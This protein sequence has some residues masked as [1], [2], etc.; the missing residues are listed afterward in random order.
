MRVGV[1]R[2]DMGRG[3]HLDDLLPRNQYPYASQVAGQSR[4]IHKPTDAELEAA[5][6]PY[7][8]LAT[9]VLIATNTAA[10]V[11]TSSND[12][13]RIRTDATASFTVIAVTSGASTA[14]TVIRDDLNTEF[15]S[16][17]LNLI[18][19]IVGTNQIRIRTTSPDV[20]PGSYV[21]VDSVANGSTLSTAVGFTVGG[22][23]DTVGTSTA[24]TAAIKAAV[25]PTSTTIDV[26]SATIIAVDL[27]FAGMATD[28]QAALVLAVADVVAPKLTE[29]GYALLSF[30]KG[31]MSKMRVASFQ[32][33]GTRGGKPAGIA[34][35]VVEDDGSTAFSYP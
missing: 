27:A 7:L 33:G 15:D 28:D 30:S 29:T 20:G 21:E 35:A 34:I 31:K 12:T 2:N 4:A 6:S 26:S 3:L 19:D 9:A 25:Y 8:A 13:L 16:A 5:A 1:V 32:P 11:D 18:A 23:S 17:G 14:K 22:V 10:S 24:L